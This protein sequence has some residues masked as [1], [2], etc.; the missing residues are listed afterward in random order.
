M[1]IEEHFLIQV[2]ADHINLRKS[3]V[4]DAVDW[5][6]LK[7][8]A[9]MQQVSAIVY[10]QTKNSL[11]QSAF[12]QQLYHSKNQEM[13]VSKI[14]DELMISSVPFVFVKGVDIKQYYSFPELRSMGDADLIVHD[15]DKQQAGR[16]LELLGFEKTVE[17]NEWVYIR[18]NFEVE[19][20]HALAYD[21]DSFQASC[22]I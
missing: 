4:P 18:G 15:E 8:I 14:T 16:I 20:H 22:I 6:K 13:L 11:F 1:T 5:G 10:S 3:S 12:A 9:Q 19:L 2:L 21:K 7:Q 17:T